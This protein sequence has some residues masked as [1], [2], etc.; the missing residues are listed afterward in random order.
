MGYTL[1][2]L[3]I[4]KRRGNE[5]E[6]RVHPAF[7]PS[8]HPLSSVGGAYNAVYLQGD[9]VG[10]LMLYG[11][12]AGD[13][14]TASSIVSDMVKVA[15]RTRHHYTTFDNGDRPSP[16]VSFDENW[17][18]GYFL[19]L[20]V[21]DRPGVMYRLS[22]ILSAHGLSIASVSQPKRALGMEKVP[23]IIVTYPSHEQAMRLAVEEMRALPETDGNVVVVRLE[24]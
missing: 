10:N 8:D 24:E 3:A 23:V 16:L 5:L 20:H 7:L 12:G 18:C 11:Q 13:M 15:T 2:A 22:G 6:V 14:P 4:A 21:T 17:E 19:C 9:A 1:K